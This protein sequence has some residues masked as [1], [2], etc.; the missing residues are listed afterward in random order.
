MMKLAAGRAAVMALIAIFTM[1]MPAQA[2]PTKVDLSVTE[3]IVEAAQALL[4]SVPQE[5]NYIEK[6][7]GYS[8]RQLLLHDF[9]D[10]AR[11]DWAYWPRARAGLPLGSMAAEQRRLVHDLLA[12]ILSTK[13]QLKMVAIL[14]LEE[15]FRNMDETNFPRHAEDYHLVFFGTPSKQRAW[16]LRFEG[17]HISMSVTIPAPGEISIT[18]LFLGALPSIVPAGPFAGLRVLRQEEDLARGLVLSLDETQRKL[19]IQSNT[20]PGDILSGQ[21]GKEASSWRSWKQALQ[22]NGLP[23]AALSA[24]QREIVRKLIHEVITSYRPEIAERYEASIDWP[25]LNFIWMG[26][27]EPNRPHYYRIQS[28]NFV[29][30]YANTQNGGRHIHTVWRDSQA[31][32]GSTSQ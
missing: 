3:Q 18:P 21:N 13:G 20:P 32:L 25:R 2:Q 31:D 16:A 5:P 17:H 12:T 6:A 26:S 29:Y 27:T 19:A 10:S 28:G 14:Q 9:N 7:F 23:I 30:E 4:A 24:A 15:I 1:A 11:Q 8:Q 22:P